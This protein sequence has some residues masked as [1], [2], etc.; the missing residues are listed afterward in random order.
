M[1]CHSEYTIPKKIIQPSSVANVETKSVEDLECRQLLNK[2]WKRQLS[3][4]W[5]LAIWICSLSGKKKKE[6]L[7]IGEMCLGTTEVGL[8][9]SRGVFDLLMVMAGSMS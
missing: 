2:L 7:M 5:I 6:W 9:C 4:V 1:Y 3:Y 8:G